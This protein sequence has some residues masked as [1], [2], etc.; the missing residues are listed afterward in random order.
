MPSKLDLAIALYPDAKNDAVNAFF[1]AISIL[2]VSLWFEWVIENPFGVLVSFVP[3]F[4]F[5]YRTHDLLRT[6]K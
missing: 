3:L 6:I 2:I 5:V 4:I 1:N